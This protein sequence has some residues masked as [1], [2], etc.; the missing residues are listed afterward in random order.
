MRWPL[1]PHLRLPTPV[2]ISCLNYGCRA[3]VPVWRYEWLPVEVRREGRLKGIAVSTRTI[4]VSGRWGAILEITLRNTLKAPQSIP[5]HF[6][7]GG[8]LEYVQTWDFSRPDTVKYKTSAT[9][10]SDKILFGLFGFGLGADYML[11]PPMAAQECKDSGRT[12]S[13]DREQ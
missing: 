12:G 3:S 6:S 2:P 5:V 8:S 13:G 4:L 1:A 10:A 9:A 11:I 7:I